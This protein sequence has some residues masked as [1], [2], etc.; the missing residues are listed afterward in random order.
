VATAELSP[1]HIAA[2]THSD[3]DEELAA[4]PAAPAAAA[5]TAAAPTAS[6]AATAHPQ[7]LVPSA[8]GGLV[9][10]K[11][12]AQEDKLKTLFDLVQKLTLVNI[13]H[14]RTGWVAMNLR[15][16]VPCKQ[17]PPR[18]C[19]PVWLPVS[20]PVLPVDIPLLYAP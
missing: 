3:S 9:A 6:A 12:P 1:E 15:L 10:P 5:P 13:D 20:S 8:L 14:T 7:N 2:L 17:R 16:L 18:A 4:A 11:A 19:L